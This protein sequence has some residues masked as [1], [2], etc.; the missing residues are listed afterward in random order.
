MSTSP[1]LQSPQPD[2]TPDPVA[3]E[4]IGS[5]TAELGSEGGSYGDLTQSVRAHDES[6]TKQVQGSSSL[7]FGLNTILALVL[8][9][10]MALAMFYWIVV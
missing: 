1:H 8:L 9:A 3:R 7:A 10:A 2:P 4:P 6:A 5:S